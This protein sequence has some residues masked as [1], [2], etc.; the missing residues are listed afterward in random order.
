MILI[1]Y[2]NIIISHSKRIVKDFLTAPARFEL[3]NARIKIW[4]LTIWLRG[5]IVVA[6]QPPHS[7]LHRYIFNTRLRDITQN[8][9][10]IFLT[11]EPG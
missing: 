1:I 2:Y 6:L 11:L 8:L 3:A 9:L 5:Q 7:L 4:C 10:T